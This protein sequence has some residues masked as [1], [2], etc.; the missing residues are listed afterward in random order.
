MY[1]YKYMS[2]VVIS[3]PQHRVF[4]SH[5]SKMGVIYMKS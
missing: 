3:D 4:K 5:R 1:I 2:Q